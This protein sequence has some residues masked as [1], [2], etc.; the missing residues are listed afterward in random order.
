M[1]SV[2][3]VDGDKHLNNTYS[4][5]KF[6]CLWTSAQA[7]VTSVLTVL[8]YS[9]LFFN[10]VCLFLILFLLQ[11]NNFPAVVKA[12]YL[13]YADDTTFQTFILTLSL[14]RRLSVTLSRMPQFSG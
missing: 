11:I 6:Y 10:L 2:I 14:C 5:S 13:L 12:R 4:D 1:E 9:C 7:T 3:T 8:S